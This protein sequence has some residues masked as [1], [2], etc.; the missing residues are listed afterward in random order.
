MGAAAGLAL[1]GAIAGL[2][3]PRRRSAHP[4][5]ATIERHPAKAETVR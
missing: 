4:V 1:A 5:S 3:V 2:V